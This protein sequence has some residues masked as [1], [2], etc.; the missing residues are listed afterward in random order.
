LERAILRILRRRFDAFEPDLPDRLAE[1][2]P[3]ELE[4]LLDQAITAVDYAAFTTFLVN[5]EE[6]R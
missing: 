2:P 1:L 5:V 4:E 3:A 6:R